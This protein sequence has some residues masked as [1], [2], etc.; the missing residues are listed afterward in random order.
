MIDVK[1]AVR[2]AINYAR[3]IFPDDQFD[4]FT[5]EEVELDDKRPFWYITLGMGK[6]VQESPLELLSGGTKLAVKYKV[7]KIHR[8]T[9][10]VHSVKMRKE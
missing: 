5:L 3:E 6:V 7:F 4:K 9:G 8:E 2:I 1:D 10:Q